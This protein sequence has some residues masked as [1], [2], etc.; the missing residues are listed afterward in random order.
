MVL[1]NSCYLSHIRIGC[2]HLWPAA[3]LLIFE[4]LP[5]LP[6]SMVPTFNNHTWHS[7]LTIH[8]F[9]YFK[10]FCCGK[11]EFRPKFY[12][13][14]LLDVFNNFKL[15]QNLLTYTDN[16]SWCNAAYELIH[17]KFHIWWWEGFRNEYQKFHE[18]GT[19]SI[20]LGTHSSKLMGHAVC[21]L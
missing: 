7:G 1:H 8:S 9:H 15:W 13:D 10:R 17:L 18:D 12:C 11:T 20:E 4:W 16:G 2:H 14:V 21:R 5:P 19:T 3:S 6:K